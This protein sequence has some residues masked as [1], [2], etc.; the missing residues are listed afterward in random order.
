MPLQNATIASLLPSSTAVIIDGGSGRQGSELGMTLNPSRL[1]TSAT[2]RPPLMASPVV[3]GP[4]NKPVQA[5]HGA[6][7]QISSG[8]LSSGAQGCGTRRLPS[9]PSD[10]YAQLSRGRQLLL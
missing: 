5:K 7:Q 1:M 8:C 3:W 6:V 10:S 2:R 9:R 4:W